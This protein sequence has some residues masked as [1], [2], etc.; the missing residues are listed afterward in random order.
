MA[1]YAHPEVLVTTAVGGG[2]RERSQGPPGRGGCGHDGLRSGPHRGRRRLELADAASGQRPPRSDREI[3][4][5]EDCS[6]SPA[7]RTTRRSFSTATTTTG[8]RRMRFWQLK[9][10]GHKDVRLMN[11]GRKKWVEEKR[12]LT[13]EAAKVAP[14]TYRATGPDESIRAYREEQCFAIVRKKVER[15]ASWTCVRSMNSPAKSSRRRA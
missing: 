7:S 11:G 14:T 4:A 13:T 15:T 3:R 2:P 10:Y 6:A 1:E 5:R 8:S 9:Y 12:P